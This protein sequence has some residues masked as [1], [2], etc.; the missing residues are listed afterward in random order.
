[1]LSNALEGLFL[2][3]AGRAGEALESLHKTLALDTQFWLTHFYLSSVY[4]ETGRFAESLAEAG[5]ARKCSG[6]SSTLAMAAAACA[7]VKLRKR[8]DAK[9]LLDELLQLSDRKYVPP[10]HFALLYN[11]LDEIEETLAWLKRGLE[12][13]DPKMTFLQVD[14]K[15]NNLRGTPGFIDIVRR[16]GLSPGAADYA[17]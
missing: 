1:M 17:R 4:L 14:P 16:V 15:W 10:Y 3:N 6:G 8:K 11:G 9:I 5:E 13:R 2:L 12:Q 7:L